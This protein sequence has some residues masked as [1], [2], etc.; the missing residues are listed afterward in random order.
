MLGPFL[1]PVSLMLPP[2][3]T[4]PILLPSK[5][6]AR[7]EWQLGYRRENLKETFKELG[8]GGAAEYLYGLLPPLHQPP[9][10]QILRKLSQEPVATAIP[11]AV[12]PRQLTLLSWPERMPE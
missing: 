11:S 9:Q 1:V 12:T 3:G 8:R 5:E 6:T 4:L 10:F 7:W 2:R